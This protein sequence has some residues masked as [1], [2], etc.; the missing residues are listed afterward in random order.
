MKLTEKEEKGLRIGSFSLGSKAAAEPQAVGKLFSE[1]PVRAETIMQSLGKVWCPFKGIDCR[2]L[3]DNIFLFTFHQASGRRRALDDGPWNFDKDLL[4]VTEF[5]ASKTVEELKF[6]TIPIWV[7]IMKMPLGMMRKEVGKEIGDLIGKFVEMEGEE[8]EVKAGKFL[9]VKVRM[10]ITKPLMRGIKLTVEVVGGEKEAWCP[11]QYEFLPDFCYICGIIG[12]VDK[13]CETQLEDGAERQY[14]SKLRFIP[15]KKKSLMNRYVGEGPPRSKLSWRS[16]GAG[17]R[18]SWSGGSSGGSDK[19]SWRKE[20]SRREEDKSGKGEE[21]EVTSPLKLCGGGKTVEK[22]VLLAK[23]HLAF[24]A[25]AENREAPMLN[26]D[27]TSKKEL[28]PP[29]STTGMN[30]TMHAVSETKE[31]S[32]KRKQGTYK[33]VPREKG[34]KG[35]DGVEKSLLGTKRRGD[36]EMEEMEVDGV[37]VQK[38]HR[39]V[40][41]MTQTLNEAGPADRSCGAQ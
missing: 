23:K 13:G 35:K 22:E 26:E 38:K 28:I 5:D 24:P 16:G 34:G 37:E 18:E 20:D 27:M 17:N 30:S 33:R 36:E 29:Q 25:A 9:R 2:E 14:S 41:T 31:A 1:R 32:P 15:E 6:D 19:P 21:K 10:N 7:R 12:H 4:V 8:G 40:T 39:K 11:F 3:G